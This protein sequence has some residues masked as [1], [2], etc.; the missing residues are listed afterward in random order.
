MY[1]DVQGTCIYIL[2][3]SMGFQMDFGVLL[4]YFILRI[5]LDG[6]LASASYT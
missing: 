3:V 5:K 2:P 1:M 4:F 6:A